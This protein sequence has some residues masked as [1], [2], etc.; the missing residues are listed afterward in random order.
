MSQVKVGCSQGGTVFIHESL[1]WAH[2]R[3]PLHR[4]ELTQQAW[5]A[6]AREM[7]I[8]VTDFVWLP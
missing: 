5:A 1:Q 8:L 4:K 2:Q 7:P 3:D 6:H